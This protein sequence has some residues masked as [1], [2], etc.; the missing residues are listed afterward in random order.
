MKNRNLPVGWMVRYS[1]ESGF[2]LLAVFLHCK[3]YFFFVKATFKVYLLATQKWQNL[4]WTF[5]AS[6][7][8]FSYFVQLLQVQIVKQSKLNMKV[9]RSSVLNLLHRFSFYFSLFLYSFYFSFFIFHSTSVSFNVLFFFCAFLSSIAVPLLLCTSIT[10][11][12]SRG[13]RLNHLWVTWLI[14]LG[15]EI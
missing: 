13:Y 14:F 15:N 1:T 11:F 3:Y 2:Q 6:H 5:F 12:N 4:E 10:N 8:C 7:L 9:L